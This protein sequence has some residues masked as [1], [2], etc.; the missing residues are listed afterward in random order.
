MTTP[1]P[2]PAPNAGMTDEDLARAHVG[3]PPKSSDRIDFPFPETQQRMDDYSAGLKKGR[4]LERERIKA[5]MCSFPNGGDIWDIF[6]RS[7]FPSES[8]GGGG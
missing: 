3:Y 6:Q 4:E 8:E 7:F 2:T 1:E 5:T